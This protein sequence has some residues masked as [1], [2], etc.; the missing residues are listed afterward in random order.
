MAIA[1][2]IFSC[3]QQNHVIRRENRVVCRENEK[4]R[5]IND[6]M[7]GVNIKEEN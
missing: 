1:M 3:K 6:I 2:Q 7:H 4:K 5:M